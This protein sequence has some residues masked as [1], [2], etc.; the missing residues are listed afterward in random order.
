M[1]KQQLS[2]LPYDSNVKTE[3]SIANEATY[4]NGGGTAAYSGAEVNSTKIM[5]ANDR[6]RFQN[7][8]AQRKYRKFQRH[9]SM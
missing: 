8:I 4:Q 2:S 3:M 1:S 6:R 7:R 9:R 5:D